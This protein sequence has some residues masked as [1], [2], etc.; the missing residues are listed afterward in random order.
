MITTLTNSFTTF[1]KK[2]RFKDLATSVKHC[3]L[4]ERM[5]HRTKVLSFDNGNINSKILFIAEAP[6]RLGADKTGIPLYGDRTGDNFDKLL[7]NIGWKRD[8]IFITN[9]IICNPQKENGSN[10][11]PTATEI[12]NCSF[13][14][15]MVINLVNPTLIVT[16][17]R[18]ALTSLNYIHQHNIELRNNVAT[19]QKWQNHYLYP[20]YHPGP[21][22][23]IHRSFAKQTSD[24]IKLSKIIDPIL[25][26]KDLSKTVRSN[27]RHQT[28]FQPQPLHETIFV[29]LQSIHEISFFKLTKFLYLIDLQSINMYGHSITNQIFLRQVDGPWMPN[30]KN[31]ISQMDKHELNKYFKAGKLFLQIG[32]NPRFDIKLDDKAIEIIIDVIVKYGTHSNFEIKSKVYQTKPMRY[33]LKQEKEG[34]KMVNKPIIYKNKIIATSA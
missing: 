28:S 25:G 3:R 34:A 4:C 23:L 20:L 33:I 29:V 16:L 1:N 18:T 21:R 11:T 15:E 30:L 6:G 17:G 19:I 24:F 12:K 22:A 9:A 14:L 13:Y 2:T 10:G 27:I 8:D 31:I 32:H 5:A 7:G 26:L